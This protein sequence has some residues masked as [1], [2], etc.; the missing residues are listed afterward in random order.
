MRYI[1]ANH[2][3]SG[4]DFLKPNTVI[5]LDDKNQ[6]ID[7]ISSNAIEPSNIEHFEG[8]IS[9]GFIN[10]HC[11]LELSHLKNHI[12]PKTGIVNFALDIIKKRNF[13]ELK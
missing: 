10:T 3:F 12:E 4:N 8:I 6:I 11:H 7:L 1:T 5:V 13:Y 2:I 9:P